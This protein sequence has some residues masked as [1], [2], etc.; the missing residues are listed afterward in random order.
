M[1]SV[2]VRTM[3]IITATMIVGIASVSLAILVVI[4]MD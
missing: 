1:P 3:A 2:M 4:L